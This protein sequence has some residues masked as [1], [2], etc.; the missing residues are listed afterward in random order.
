ML[1]KRV[2]VGR[3]TLLWTENARGEGATLLS[4]WATG[5]AWSQRF[6]VKGLLTAPLVTLGRRL[7]PL[8]DQER[9]PTIFPALPTS[10]FQ[11]VQFVDTFRE[12]VSQLLWLENIFHF[13]QSTFNLALTIFHRLLV[14]VKVGRPLQ[15]G[16]RWWERRLTS[17]PRGCSS[18]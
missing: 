15:A 8:M 2:C 10:S 3:G 17:A 4:R 7:L 18:R 5:G 1:G 13:S 12:V 11:Q 6:K 14:S 9:P 16:D